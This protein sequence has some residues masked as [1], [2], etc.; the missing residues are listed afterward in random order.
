MRKARKAKLIHLQSWR[1]WRR[2]FVIFAVN[3]FII[4]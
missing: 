3:G 2:T 4:I 1:T